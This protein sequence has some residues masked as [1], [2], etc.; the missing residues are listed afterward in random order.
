MNGEN[1]LC[2]LIFGVW[3]LLWWLEAVSGG[4]AAFVHEQPSLDAR[5][6][7]KVDRSRQGRIWQKARLTARGYN[8]MRYTVRMHSITNMHACHTTFQTQTQH[9]HRV[10]LTVDGIARGLDE[11]SGHDERL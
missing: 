1:G 4:E 11:H 3:A 8:S 5:C 10:V 7:S 2:L 9:P 6:T